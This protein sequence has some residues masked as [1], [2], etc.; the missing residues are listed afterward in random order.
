MTKRILIAL[1]FVLTACGGSEPAA[2]NVPTNS[3]TPNVGMKVVSGLG[4]YKVDSGSGTLLGYSYENSLLDGGDHYVVCS[5]S[6]PT[7]QTSNSHLYKAGTAGATTGSCHVG[8]DIDTPSAGYWSFGTIG[9][10]A[11]VYY[12]DSGSVHNNYQY[13]FTSDCSNY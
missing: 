3:T 11:E 12:L 13:T 1:T 9:S 8:F 5:V 10:V 7:Y 4:C 6:G 2:V